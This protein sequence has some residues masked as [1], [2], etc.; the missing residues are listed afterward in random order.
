[1]ADSQSRLTASP[2]R[3]RS[4]PGRVRLGLLD[5]SGDV[6]AD[7]QSLLTASPTRAWCH[8]C[9]DG[10]QGLA[11]FKLGVAD[12]LTHSLLA[13]FGRPGFYSAPGSGWGRRGGSAV[14]PHGG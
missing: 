3:A 11:R 10:R 9:R 12:G 14:V 8:S 5:H 6:M 7:S 1:M 4:R 2:T 13:R